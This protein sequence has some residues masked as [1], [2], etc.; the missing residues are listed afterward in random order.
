V[1]CLTAGTKVVWRAFIVG[2]AEGDK[3]YLGMQQAFI[4]I[5]IESSPT[6]LI[7]RL[8]IAQ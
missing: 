2:A 5:N 3:F 8:N 1:Q 4:D 6:A 7:A